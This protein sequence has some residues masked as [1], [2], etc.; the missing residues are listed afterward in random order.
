MAARQ[1]DPIKREYYCLTQDGMP[2]RKAL[3]N[4]HDSLAD[5]FDVFYGPY[6]GENGIRPQLHQDT[7]KRPKAFKDR[8]ELLK[9][10]EERCGL[11]NEISIFNAATGEVIVLGGSGE[12]AVTSASVKPNLKSLPPIHLESAQDKHDAIQNNTVSNQDNVE[13]IQDKLSHS[14]N[15]VKPQVA[16]SV[17]PPKSIHTHHHSLTASSIS[18][19]PV[20]KLM[21][22]HGLFGTKIKTSR[23]LAFK[24]SVSG[25]AQAKPTQ[26]NFGIKLDSDG[27]DNTFAPAA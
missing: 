6:H 14:I 19:V 4:P 3:K 11:T 13:T 2:V 9:F 23:S 1:K 22:V 18:D 10:F 20:S 21:N 25:A 7:D 12:H 27:P 8:N 16:K 15:L 26:L 5:S 24:G 17:N